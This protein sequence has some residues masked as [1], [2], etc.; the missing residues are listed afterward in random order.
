MYNLF[1]VVE[2]LQPEA[3]ERLIIIFI[4][5]IH[6]HSSKN[7]G[8]FGIFIFTRNIRRHWCFRRLKSV[9]Y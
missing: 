6:D 5:I 2:C 7:V 8:R 3:T 1:S 4:S 9:I